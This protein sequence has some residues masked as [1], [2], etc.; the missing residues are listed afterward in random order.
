MQSNEELLQI[1]IN[2]GVATYETSQN[3]QWAKPTNFYW[4]KS[5][6][7]SMV[8]RTLREVDFLCE[9]YG[10][11]YIKIVCEAPQ[12][13]EIAQ[14][15]PYFFELDNNIFL[16][17]CYDK[18]YIC[19]IKVEIYMKDD[20]LV[21]NPIFDEN[22]SHIIYSSTIR[23]HHYAEAYASLYLKLKEAGLLEKEANNA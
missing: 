22:N 4:C 16:D 12:M 6:Y 13:H 23:N 5:Y 9:K 15:L 21:V 8:V 2:Y 14:R 19:Y 1:A 11:N 10:K 7:G 3:L 17:L 20:K 18:T